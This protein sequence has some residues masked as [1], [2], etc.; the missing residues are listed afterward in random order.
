M[1]LID[2]VVSYNFFVDIQGM[3]VAQFK[4]VSGLGISISVIE[5]RANQ[6]MAQPV[7]QKLPGSVH[8]EDIHLSRGKIV[9]PAFWAWM[10]QVQDG[11][12][13]D[14][15]KDGSIILYDFPHL[16]LTRFNFYGAWPYKIEIGKL[17]AGADSVLL[18][19]MVL[20]VERIEVG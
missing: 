1:A 6:A 10:K 3:T 19:S 12:I 4:E 15:R 14:A 18:E 8:Y 2:P 13:E 9:D 5:H 11:H 20:A 7:V 17:Q 16:E